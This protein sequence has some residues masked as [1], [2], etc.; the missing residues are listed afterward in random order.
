[1]EVMTMK[2]DGDQGQETTDTQRNK[3]QDSR[4]KYQIP[5]VIPLGEAARSFGADLRCNMGSVPEAP[6]C[7]SG[8]TAGPNCISGSMPQNNCITGSSR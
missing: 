7:M 6:N 2:K 1:M 3:S 5:V 8:M 4:S